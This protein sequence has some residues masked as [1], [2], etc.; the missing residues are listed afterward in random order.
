MNT[1]CQS[2]HK[3]FSSQAFQRL[4]SR[5]ARQIT[6]Y[7]SR[8][9][10]SYHT[11]TCASVNDIGKPCPTPID[12]LVDP[13]L[14]NEDLRS[15]SAKSDC[16]DDDLRDDEG[17][18]PITWDKYGHTPSFSVSIIHERKGSIQSDSSWS[19][20]LSSSLFVESLN[21]KGSPPS[22][23]ASPV[24][25]DSVE[26]TKRKGPVEEARAMEDT[27][28]WLL[29]SDSLAWWMIFLAFRDRQILGIYRSFYQALI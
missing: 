18:I 4:I 27:M 25:G 9:S 29:E 28:R 17:W 19:S 16:S 24:F 7:L 14:D 8:R 1:H 11:S 23:P 22:T 21:E 20:V 15:I 13:Y 10:S 26:R 6:R 12:I 3:T 2:C 5:R